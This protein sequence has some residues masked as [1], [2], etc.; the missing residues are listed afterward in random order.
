MNNILEKVKKIVLALTPA[1]VGI[2]ATF[3][4]DGAAIASATETFLLAAI[5][6][7]QFWVNRKTKK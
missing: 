7:V 3:G 4:W 2:G 5:Q 1:I 6:Y